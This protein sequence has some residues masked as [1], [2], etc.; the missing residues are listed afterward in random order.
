[1]DRVSSH[2]ESLRQVLPVVGVALLARLVLAALI[3]L[4]PD[5][6]YYWEWSRRLAGGYFDHPSAIAVLIAAGTRTA[7]LFGVAPLPFVVRVVPVIAG[8]VAA[9]FAAL[10]AGRLAGPAAARTAAVIFAVMPLAASG[11]VI[12]TPD[13]PLLAANAIA[14]Y[15]VVRA[16]QS[17]PR[18]REAAG[19]WT[20]GGIF[21]GASFASKYTSILLPGTLFVGMLLRR[22]TRARLAEAGP[23]LACVAAILVFLP[24]LRWNAGH[25]W[26]S[27]SFQIQHGLGTPT[28]SA[29]KREG[30]L[31][32]G[33]LGLVSPILFVL[34]AAAVWQT[35]RN[36]ADDVRFLLA[37]IAVG[38][39]VFFGYSALRRS[40]EANW[41]APAYIPAVALL[42]ALP[43]SPARERWV[44]RGIA[45]GGLVVA[46]I[47][48]H[49]VVPLLPLKAR[50][51]PIARSAGW[52]GL[53]SSVEKMSGTLSG[54]T[55]VGADRYQ[56]V[57]ELAYHLQGRPTTFCTCLTGRR[58]Q[59]ELW[60]GFA[61]TAHPGDNLVL[62][63]EDTSSG[64][65][66]PKLLAPYFAVVAEGEI[67]PLLR[68]GDTV[69]VRRL[70]A[71][72]N[73][74]EGWPTRTAVDAR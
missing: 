71:L 26:I 1:M 66:S 40:V 39:W 29:L 33:Q 20:L 54:H 55:Y 60:P 25:D 38:S 67:V 48:I 63:L 64:A 16:L 74:R 59:Y 11:L 65:A 69:A 57:S 27:F 56:D 62:S 9:L 23:W 36:R 5:E 2:D 45:L 28:G 44:K 10:I 68:G 7:A 8:A 15:G 14:V 47:Y 24:V 13:I 46:L 12:A 49:A 17:Q 19:W 37:A 41:P 4:F 6:T 70:W 72:R 73:Y 22:S 43:G 18:S 21:L 34:I 50:R 51:D 3:P 61:Q 30:D 58:N 52:D 42:A 35:L 53:A 31:L 32:G